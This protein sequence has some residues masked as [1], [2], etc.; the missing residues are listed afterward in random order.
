MVV[1]L[2]HTLQ[3]CPWFRKLLRSRFRM[4]IIANAV[5]KLISGPTALTA[6]DHGQ[7]FCRNKGFGGPDMNTADG[8]PTSSSRPAM[9][10]KLIYYP[11]SIVL[12][13]D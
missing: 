6:H 8:S 12:G 13:V 4:L 9:R 10:D 7:S 5:Y 1:H 3:P 11:H 2:Q